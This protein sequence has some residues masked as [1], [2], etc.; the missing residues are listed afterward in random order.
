MNK[1][2]VQK[3]EEVVE[4]KKEEKP[5]TFWNTIVRKSSSIT[6]SWT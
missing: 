6:S 2:K 5:F 3:E 4:E 1:A